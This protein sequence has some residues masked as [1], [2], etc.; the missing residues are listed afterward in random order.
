MEKTLTNG[1][2][3][4]CCKDA[5]NLKPAPEESN[6]PEL[7]VKK[8]QVCGRRHFRLKAEPGVFGLVMR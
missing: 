7:T 3:N 2:V 1:Q 5:E 4:E 6:R 8:C